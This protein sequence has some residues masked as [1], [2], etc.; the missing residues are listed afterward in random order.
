M[1]SIVV[2]SAGDYMHLWRSGGGAGKTDHGRKD[3]KHAKGTVP[4]PLIQK[5]KAAVSFWTCHFFGPRSGIIVNRTTSKLPSS[6]PRC[7]HFSLGQQ[8]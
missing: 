2:S 7:P 1:R 6:E 4:V 5:L 3:K 8:L